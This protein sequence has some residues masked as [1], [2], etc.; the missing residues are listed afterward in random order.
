MDEDAFVHDR[1]TGATRRVSVALDGAQTD[2]NTFRSVLASDG[3]SVAM[4]SRA[5]N[6]VPCDANGADDI[7]VRTLP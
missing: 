2:D 4:Y 3:R 5:T 1:M 7:F 6:L